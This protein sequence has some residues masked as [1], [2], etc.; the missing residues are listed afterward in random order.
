MPA[1]VIANCAKLAAEWQ[2]YVMRTRSLRKVFLSIKGIYFQ[3]SVKGETVTWLVPY[4]FTQ[5]IPSDIDFRIML[6]FLELYQTL[7][8]FV[9]FRLYS[10]INLVYPPPLDASKDDEAA[11]LGALLLQETSRT[12]TIEGEAGTEADL[13]SSKKITT[14]DVKKQI[15]QITNASHATVTDDDASEA[16][17]NGDAAMDV[18]AQPV[19]STSTATDIPKSL[20]PDAPDAEAGPSDEELTGLFNGYCFYLSREVTRPTLEFVIRAFGGQVGWDAV[21]G[22]GS[23][24]TVDDPQITHHI[25]D[26]PVG[27]ASTAPG[28]ST[29]LVA[30]NHT[31]KRASIQPQWVVDCINLRKLLPTEPYAPGAILPPHLSPFVDAAKVREQGGY[32]PTEA[33][34]QAVSEGESE[35]EAEVDEEQVAVDE[36][37][38]TGFGGDDAEQAAAIDEDAEAQDE[39]EE[40]N[41]AVPRPA[42]AAA[43]ADPSNDA[44]VH[45]AELEAESH[46][47][48]AGTFQAE[49]AAATKASAS[50]HK[51][52]KKAAKVAPAP[53][54][55]SAATQE[56][57]PASILL[58]NKQRK[59]YNKMKFGEN[60]RSNEAEVLREKKKKLL[61]Q[62]KRA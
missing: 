26:R 15:R 46:G 62:E 12:L 44:L 10:D 55:V 52:S 3:A 35:S 21:L 50:S 6:T 8:G 33:G 5:N 49:L 38:F 53:G 47:I 25:I 2:L 34:G 40:D 39:T 14:K 48:P 22:A 61:K 42:L 32:I 28:Q 1:A 17:T 36:E 54:A 9:F 11:G 37:E 16:V 30:T 19:A 20:D 59:L 58:S 31:N 41:I 45:A 51:A 57:N 23:P 13:Q 24:Y 4:M 7:L 29:A 18:D 56:A 60:K 27:S 43:A